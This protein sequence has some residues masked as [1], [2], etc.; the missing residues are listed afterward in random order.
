MKA[1]I[2]GVP[3]SGDIGRIESDDQVKEQY[4]MEFHTTLDVTRVQ[5]LSG[6]TRFVEGT[7]LHE[8]Q[9]EED[10]AMVEETDD[11]DDDG[12]RIRI[13]P[14]RRK[15]Q[16]FAD[17]VAVEARN[18][19]SGFAAVSTSSA[20]FIFDVI[21]SL[22]DPPAEI[23]RAQ[24]DL[25]DWVRDRPGFTVEG[26]GASETGSPNAQTVMSWGDDLEEDDQVGQYIDSA[27]RSNLVP[28][29]NGRYQWDG[30]IV[31]CNIAASGW[32]EVWK[33]E[34]GTYDWLEWVEQ[35]I[36]PY[37]NEGEM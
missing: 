29:V 34:M 20:E 33:P 11:D 9:V 18:D 35:E 6:D 32:V 3:V 23:W 37:V 21:G 31:H 25:G 10:G 12:F 13:R 19:H 16:S 17:F 28:I 7:G 24:L 36:L 15:E 27:L 5:D 30:R 8:E 22:S 1:G 4:G 14:R 2:V 26:G